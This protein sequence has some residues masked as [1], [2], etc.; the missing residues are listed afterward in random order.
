METYQLHLCAQRSTNSSPAGVAPRMAKKATAT[1]PACCWLGLSCTWGERAEDVLNRRRGVSQLAGLIYMAAC[2]YKLK[3]AHPSS[4][5]LNMQYIDKTSAYT[6]LGYTA[7]ACNLFFLYG[8]LPAKESLH[9]CAQRSTNS[10]PAGVAPHMAKKA[11]ATPPACC[12][13]GLSCTWGERAEDVLN[14]R[15]GVSQLAG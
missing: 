9:L 2:C 6:C 1:P 3:H 12:W 5:A 4:K 7:S 8:D 11:T 10:S 15:R 13:L 14:R